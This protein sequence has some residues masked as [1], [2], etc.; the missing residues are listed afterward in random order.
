MYRAPFVIYLFAIG[1]AKLNQRGQER[2]KGRERKR[3]RRELNS[4]ANA[5]QL[6]LEINVS[7]FVNYMFAVP[8]D[9]RAIA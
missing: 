8:V 6:K 5:Y 4:L 9:R 1:V 2:E 3:E 7:R